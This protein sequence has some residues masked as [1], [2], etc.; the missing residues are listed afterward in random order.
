[1]KVV[2]R[3]KSVQ[4]VKPRITMW[5][6]AWVIKELGF[7]LGD[8]SEW[9]PLEDDNGERLVALRRIPGKKEGEGEEEEKKE[10]GGED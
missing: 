6:P 7:E 3:R 2:Q 10:E 4:E 5:V 1:M 8:E 9:V